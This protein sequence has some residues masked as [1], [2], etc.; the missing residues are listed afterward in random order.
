MKEKLKE[1]LFIYLF[2]LSGK[3]E[4]AFYSLFLFFGVKGNSYLN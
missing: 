2:C 4:G 1:Q 3:D